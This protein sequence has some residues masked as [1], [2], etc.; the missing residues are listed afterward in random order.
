MTQERLDRSDNRKR[1]AEHDAAALSSVADG[2][3]AAGKDHRMD[4]ARHLERASV[5]YE[6]SAFLAGQAGWDC[7]APFAHTPLA[8]CPI[9]DAVPVALDEITEG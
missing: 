8:G 7:V 6:C 3:I 1:I 4:A 2:L 9:C 5:V